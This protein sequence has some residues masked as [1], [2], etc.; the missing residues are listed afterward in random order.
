MPITIQLLPDAIAFFRPVSTHQS[1]EMP[2]FHRDGGGRWGGWLG[3]VLVGRLW[4][5]LRFLLLIQPFGRDELWNA[6]DHLHRP[7]GMVELAV[8][9]ITKFSISVAPPPPIPLM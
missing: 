1:R 5:V 6:V 7:L 3:G 4:V 2:D 8:V 9:Q